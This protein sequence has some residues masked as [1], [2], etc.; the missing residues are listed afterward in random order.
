[1]LSGL[2]YDKA[3]LYSVVVFNSAGSVQSSNATLN[4][5]IPATFTQQPADVDVRVRPDLQSDVAPVTNATFTISVNSANPP[6]S[7]QWRVNGTNIAATNI[8]GI[9]TA[10]LLVSNVS[11][12]NFGAYSCAVTDG[13]GTLSSAP[14]TLYPLVRPLVSVGPPTPLSV[15]AGQPIP[16]SVVLSNGFPP[17]FGYQWRSN[18]VAIATPVSNSKTNFFVIPAAFV[19]TNAVTATYRVI[20][21]NRAVTTFQVAQSATFSVSTLLDTDRDGIPDSAEIALG[22]MTNNAADALSDLDGDGVSNIAEYQAGTSLND[23]NSFLRVTIT[24]SN[25]LARL[26]VAAVSNRTY[27][28]Q[29]SDALPASWNKLADLIARATN[30][31][32]LLVD[33][34]WTTNRFYR[35]VLPAQ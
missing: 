12:E 6:V 24:A 29:Y 5:L 4:I 31:V 27:T 11:V 15:P 23:S 8:F 22:L 26:S 13:N 17:P 18:A 28:V 7:Y 32:E 19:A 20:V 35:A 1:M 30:R 2:T 9:N 3:G 34:A 16:V 21:T 33:P 10:T 14:A 25:S